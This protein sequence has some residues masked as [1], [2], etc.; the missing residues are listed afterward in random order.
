MFRIFTSLM[1]GA[2]MLMTP[3]LGYAVYDPASVPNNKYGIHVADPNDIAPTSTLVNSSGGDWGYVTFVIP[4][5]DRNINK[6]QEVFNLMR[7]LHL[8][9]MV[10]LATHVE[11]ETWTKPSTATI[12]EWVDFLSKLNWPIENRYVIIF[13]EP[14]HAKEWGNTIDPEGYAEILVSFARALKQKSE[15]FFVLPAGL[16]AS[17]ASDGQALD[18]AVFLR[19]MLAAEPEILQIIDGWTSHSYPNPGFSGSPLGWGRGTLRSYEWELD[20]LREW[21][22]QK[23]LPVF[24]TETGWIHSQ[25]KIFNPR[26]LSPQAVGENLRQAADYVWHDPRIIA[27][28]P[29]I[30][31]YQDYPFDHFSWKT[32]GG[33]DVYPH[34]LT[35]LFLPKNK[36]RPRQRQIFTLTQK[37]FPPTLVANSTYTFTTQIENS[38]QGILDA[39]DD[40][41]LVVD[42]EGRGFQSLAEGL[43]LLEPKNT[44]KLT[45]HIKTPRETGIYAI[46]VVLR[47]GKT[48]LELERQ[49]VTVVPPPSLEI[50]TQLGWRRSGNA[51]D[52]KVLIYDQDQLIQKFTG[53]AIENGAAKITGLN[54]I[55][56]NNR[57]R[58][59]VLVPYYLPRQTLEVL[60]SQT[61]SV[62]FRRFL[63]LDFNRDDTLTLSDFLALLRLKPYQVFSLFVNP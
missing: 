46:K 10:R 50:Q 12:N 22:L 32:L 52:V 51:S 48:D 55:I 19:R 58:V 8:I 54:N 33:G 53:I 16:D 35:Y 23:N 7:R 42:D 24:I 25:G 2:I 6:W 36:G 4:E 28:T 44:G 29:F 13:N 63:P 45:L 15:D 61:T 27:I 30:F 40:F 21:G 57:Y 34:Y 11:G 60:G 14:N 26:L 5:T 17:A 1:L 59:V 49:T 31:N 43:P 41:S 38:G 9:P 3:K 20:L 18:E 56:P 47:Q 39:Q 37:L 62:S